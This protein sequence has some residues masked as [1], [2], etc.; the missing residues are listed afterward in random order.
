LPDAP[1]REMVQ[2]MTSA[3]EYRAFAQHCFALAQ[4]TSDPNDRARLI[5]MAESWREL[6]ERLETRQSKKE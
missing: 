1:E 6:A 5:Q 4:K 3:D 2:R